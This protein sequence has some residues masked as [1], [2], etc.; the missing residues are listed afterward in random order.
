MKI[1]LPEVLASK[2][3]RD[4]VRLSFL[5]DIH[6]KVFFLQMFFFCTITK[7]DRLMIDGSIGIS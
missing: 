5:F 2:D 7:N 1:Y 3:Q 4:E 6:V